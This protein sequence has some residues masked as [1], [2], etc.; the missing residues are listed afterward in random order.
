MS[1]LQTNIRVRAEGLGII[2]KPI[3][4]TLVLLYDAHIQNGDGHLALVA[5]A[6]GQLAYAVTIF[7]VYRFHYGATSFIPKPIRSPSR[8]RLRFVCYNL[9]FSTV[10]T[11]PYIL[12]RLF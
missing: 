2:L 3:V 10:P 4:I 11:I 12:Q 6:L 9:V 7:W 8:R 5:F 1:E